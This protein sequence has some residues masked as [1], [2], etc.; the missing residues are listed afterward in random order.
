M[1]DALTIK[2]NLEVLQKNALFADIVTKAEIAEAARCLIGKRPSEC[3]EFFKKAFQKNPLC[4]EMLTLCISLSKDS[5]E[6]KDFSE[7]GIR[8]AL[9]NNKP[10]YSAL[11]E[12]VSVADIRIL[13]VSD[14]RYC[15]GNMSSMS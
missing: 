13:T 15:T 10:A 4:P 14:F 12:M 2:K 8:V 3:A 1:R 6:M 7:K 9:M 11:Q 5:P